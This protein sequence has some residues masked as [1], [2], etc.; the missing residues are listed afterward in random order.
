MNCAI[1]TTDDVLDFTSLAQEAVKVM[2]RERR[3][4]LL[5]KKAR[6]CLDTCRYFEERPIHKFAKWEFLSEV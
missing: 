2:E 6:A 4:S 5:A 1:S 3:V